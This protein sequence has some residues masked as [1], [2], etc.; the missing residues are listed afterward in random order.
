MTTLQLTTNGETVIFHIDETDLSFDHLRQTLRA[1]AVLMSV[2]V[3]SV[4][5]I[6]VNKEN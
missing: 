4:N 3:E 2:P 1:V 5:E 6:V